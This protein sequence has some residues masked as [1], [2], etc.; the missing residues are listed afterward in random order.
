MASL[1]EKVVIV[2]G[3]G[4]G[5]GRAA[6]IGAAREGAKIVVADDG[7]ALDGTG[8]DGAVAAA[9]CDDIRRQGGEAVSFASSLGARASAEELVKLTLDTYGRVDALFNCT[10]IV[11]DAGLLRVSE[12]SWQRMLVAHTGATLWCSRSA[13][14]VMAKQ[15]SGSIVMTTGTAAFLGN[16]GQSAYAAASAAVHGLMRTA[17]VEL[18]RHGVRVNAVAPLAK[19]RATE[20]LPLFE[21]TNTMTPDH[22]APV[23]VYLASDLSSDTTGQVLAIAGGR[24]STWRTQEALAGFKETGDGIWTVTEI[25]EHFGRVRR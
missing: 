5:I 2:T 4:R 24:I 14:Q 22:V 7:S 17:S 19:T 6:A 12:E 18:Q 8:Q 15:R 10:G 21:H 11:L 9:V 16:F 13:A 20:N 1:S 25:A 23:Y 3:A